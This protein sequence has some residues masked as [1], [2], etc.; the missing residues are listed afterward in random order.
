MSSRQR[1]STPGRLNGR[2]GNTDWA[3]RF[4]SQAGGWKSPGVRVGS[5]G[6]T[7]CGD[8]RHARG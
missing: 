6:L 8:P 1:R 5:F 2:L 7:A 4:A 3:W